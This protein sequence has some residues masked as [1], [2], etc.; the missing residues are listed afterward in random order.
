MDF[1]VRQKDAEVAL[2]PVTVA[3]GVFGLFHP[4]A[5]EIEPWGAARVEVQCVGLPARILEGKQQRARL[6]GNCVAAGPNGTGADFTLSV[7]GKIRRHYRG[8]LRTSRDRSELVAAVTMD[9]ETAVA[10]TVAAES[11]PDAPLAMLEAQAIVTRSYFAAGGRSR[12]TDFDFCDTTHC[13]FVKD[14]PSTESPAARATSETAGQ[15]LV[16]RNQVLSAFYSA[17]CEGL[18]API[19]AE[20]LAPGDYPYFAVRCEYCLKHPSTAQPKANARPH[21]HG[22][23]QLGAADL[24]Q[25]GWMDA[26]ILAHYYPG[27]ELRDAR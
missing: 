23:C 17:R 9:L 25:Q 14:P 7:P 8:T 21:H 26:R 24:A 15:V 10:S 13:Q 20:R 22:M 5:F 12:H 11:P 18:L 4:Q 3:I 1:E 2:L 27:T 16:Y 19:P 6:A